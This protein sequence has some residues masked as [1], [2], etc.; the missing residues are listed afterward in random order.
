MVLTEFSAA[1]ES[2]AT[3]AACPTFDR[4]YSGVA[5]PVSALR[6]E[7]NCG[8]GE[9]LDLKLL[10]DWCVQTGQT[11]INLL[12]VNDT[13]TNSSP[14]SALSAMALHPVYARLTELPLGDDLMHRVSEM[15]QRHNNS[16]RVAFTEIV[17][18]KEEI[19]RL[20]FLQNP[21]WYFCS[22]TARICRAALAHRTLAVFRHLKE[23][24]QGAAWYQ[25]SSATAIA[26]QLRAVIETP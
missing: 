8:I 7:Q 19:L 20:F 21:G 11:M 23:A 15:R 25:W 1:G 22:G 6:S 24:Y 4:R 12:P 16:E 3:P 17:S 13:G 5:V 26:P 10:I 9:F 18:F 2:V 14:Y